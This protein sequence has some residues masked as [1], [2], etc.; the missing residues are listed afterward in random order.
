MKLKSGKTRSRERNGELFIL[1]EVLLWSIFPV[2]TILALGTISPFY[3]ASIST[4]IAAVFFASV[5]TIKRQWHHLLRRQ[6]WKP[7]FLASLFVGC[8]FYAFIFLGLRYTTAGNASILSLMEVF[9]SFVIL[10]VLLKH[11]HILPSH[12][13]GSLLM[14]IGAGLILLPNVSGWHHGNLLVI[15]ATF[16]APWGNRYAQQA[17]KIVSAETIMFCRSVISGLFLLT[18][19]VI[20]ESTPSRGALLASTS[21]L[22]VNG[23]LLMG[24]SKIFWLEGIARLPITK[25]ISLSSLAPAF[26]LIVAYMVLHESVTS[27][28]ILGFLPIVIGVSLLT[29]KKGVIEIAV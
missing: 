16:F 28:Q 4:L 27:I 25:A 1:T 19:A 12:F 9:F 5:I 26:T 17:R 13:L 15:L 10:G 29:K 18:L 20:F 6:A 24:L 23:I 11:E 21:F 14:V 8:F 3:A 2:I 7:I 22:L